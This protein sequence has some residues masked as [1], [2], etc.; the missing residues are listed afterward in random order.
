MLRTGT[1]ISRQCAVRLASRSSL[2][3][4][5]TRTPH[6]PQSRTYAAGV[7]VDPI[8]YPVPAPFRPI[9][10]YNAANTRRR[11]V[12]EFQFPESWEGPDADPAILVRN[13]LLVK[14]YTKLPTYYERFRAAGNLSDLS[15]EEYKELLRYF[16]GNGKSGQVAL[17]VRDDM[18]AAGYQPTLETEQFILKA[19]NEGEGLGLMVQYLRKLRERRPELFESLELYHIVLQSLSTAGLHHEVITLVARLEK[20]GKPLTAKTYEYLV[21]SYGYLGLTDEAESAHK[22]MLS[23]G[24]TPTVSNF[25]AMAQVFARQ[26][27]ISRTTQYF[28]YIKRHNLKPDCAAYTALLKAYVVLGN[29]SEIIHTYSKMRKTGIAVEQETYALLIGLYGSLTKVKNAN[30]MFWKNELA[31]LLIPRNVDMY[32]AL[33]NARLNGG[34]KVAA[35]R[36]LGS[37][38]SDGLEYDYKILIPLALDSVSKHPDYIR[39]MLKLANLTAGDAKLVRQRL[40]HALLLATPPNPDAALAMIE[41]DSEGVDAGLTFVRAYALKG[42]AAK[43]A[44]VVTKV[45]AEHEGANLSEHYRYLME[46]YANAGETTKALGALEDAK[47]A[48]WGGD[49]EGYETLVR[50]LVGKGQDGAV[51]TVVEEIL[52]G[53]FVYS[54]EKSPALAAAVEGLVGADAWMRGLGL[55]QRAEPVKKAVKEET[56]DSA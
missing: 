48:G 3:I 5:P 27:K 37:V 52:E 22:R 2:L 45:K 35:W 47:K 49:V 34:E 18:I 17:Q 50:A 21:R 10:H 6:T 36:M 25:T 19:V 1:S 46:A 39:D 44:E 12:T 24:L 4:H 54:E 31:G 20:I 7:S 28:D 14:S 8:Y 40:A 43:A 26:G 53:G 33:L 9:E 41:K 30:N 29:E 42:D 16:A 38:R 23:T 56:T 51:K 13:A 55:E 15:A 11:R 32:S